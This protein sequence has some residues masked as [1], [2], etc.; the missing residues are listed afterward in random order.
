MLPMLSILFDNTPCEDGVGKNEIRLIVLC[1]P[2][3]IFSKRRKIYPQ[4]RRH[5]SDKNQTTIT[6][7]TGNNALPYILTTLCTQLL[8]SIKHHNHLTLK[9]NNK[10]KQLYFTQYSHQTFWTIDTINTSSAIP[11]AHN[12]HNVANLLYFSSI[13]S[14]SAKFTDTPSLSDRLRQIHMPTNSQLISRTH[15]HS[16]T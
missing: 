12:I 6:I 2:T 4:M 1:L 9:P 11:Y 10:H 8:V 3:E 14:F 16:H 7:Y 13:Y 15:N 5:Q